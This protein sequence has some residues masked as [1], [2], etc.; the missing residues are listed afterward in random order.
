[1]SDSDTFLDSILEGVIGTDAPPSAREQALSPNQ[2]PNPQGGP[3]LL[4]QSGGPASP[5]A[6]DVPAPVMTGLDAVL[7]GLPPMSG[8]NAHT[9]PS[10]VLQAPAPEA[11]RAESLPSPLAVPDSNVQ[12]IPEVPEAGPTDPP[13]L[14]DH[15]QIVQASGLP[16]A[17][18]HDILGLP[19]EPDVIASH[20]ELALEINGVTGT[21]P[22]VANPQSDVANPQSFASIAQE[23]ADTVDVKAQTPRRS[24]SET[25]ASELDGGSV[26]LRS[27][28]H[29]RRRVNRTT[30]VAATQAVAIVLLL[31]VGLGAEYEFVARGHSNA[32]TTLSPIATTLPNVQLP[33]VDSIAVKGFVF[34]FAT[35]G[36]AESAPFKVLSAF[37]VAVFARCSP[38]TK[39]ASVDIVL[40]TQ[41]R[42][43]ANIFLSGKVAG[44]H[45]LKSQKLAPG[46]YVVIARASSVC[47]WSAE[48]SARP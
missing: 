35:S 31:V 1:M 13:P 44:I 14:P 9:I 21:E 4:P 30:R 33:K 15:A 8:P 34:H 20:I 24:P 46:S 43:A 16:V 19:G 26:Y 11:P 6:P 42:Q 3:T 47:S 40:K 38:S 45:E 2:V 27:R 17:A 25:D 18:P 10:G 37:E 48:G 41:G 36:S 23:I 7:E 22:A 12:T 5:V 39:P 32:S 28:G 29:R